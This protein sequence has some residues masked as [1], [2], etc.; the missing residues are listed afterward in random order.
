MWIENLPPGKQRECREAQTQMIGDNFLFFVN[1]SHIYFYKFFI[2][3]CIVN[4]ENASEPILITFKNKKMDRQN[5]TTEIV[6][7]I[8]LVLA[9]I[10]LFSVVMDNFF[11][12]INLK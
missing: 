8:I 4:E 9:A 12:L 1:S 7:K 6:V 3:V 11:K 10:G 2:Y 5:H